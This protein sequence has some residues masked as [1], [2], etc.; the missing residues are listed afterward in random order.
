[1]VSP[2][3]QPDGQTVS[4]ALKLVDPLREHLGWCNTRGL[5]KGTVDQRRRVIGRFRRATGVDPLEATRDTMEK[6]WYSLTQTAGA[7]A[8]ELSHI[9]AYVSWALRHDLITR[10]PTTRID[11][12]RIP[13]RLPRPIAE[14]K[15]ERAIDQANARMRFILLIAAFCGLRC[16]EIA[17]VEYAHFIDGTDGTMLL[18]PDGKGGSPRILPVHPE[19]EDA[20]RGIPGPK[21]GR[22]VRR[23][24]GQPGAVR[25][26]RLSREINDHLHD[27]GI[28]DT[29]H[30]LRH[31]FGTDVHHIGQDLLL[32]G[33][34]M[35]QRN[36]NNTAIYVELDGARAR[37]V[38]RR[39]PGRSRRRR[40]HDPGSTAA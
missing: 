4:G 5:R 24:D 19:V 9:R 18:V 29:A 13:R 25:A 40:K 6:W 32:T 26:A 16:F 11:R 28:T 37:E 3:L 27:L 39:M 21:R 12:P 15:L 20:L 10:D 2:A 14:K 38:I 22:V 30:S 17:Q 35:G 1:M 31:R 36:L 23:L 33:T 7:R 8:V 34:M